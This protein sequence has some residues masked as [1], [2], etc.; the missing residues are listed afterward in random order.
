M[1]TPAIRKIA[2]EHFTGRLAHLRRQASAM[3][4]GWPGDPAN[5]TMRLWLAIALAAGAGPDL[6]ADTRAQIEVEAIYP[7]GSRVLPAAENIAE[8]HEYLPELARARDV[9]L[10]KA[11]ANPKDLRADQRARDLIALADALGAPGVDWSKGEP[12]RAAA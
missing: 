2:L 10:A 5:E 6:P 1:T 8:P 11:D 3:G 4:E 7:R 12:G 9:A